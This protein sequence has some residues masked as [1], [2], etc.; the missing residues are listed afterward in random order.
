MRV[1]SSKWKNLSSTESF[2][3]C[4]FHSGES[5][6]FAII[7]LCCSPSARIIQIAILSFLAFLRRKCFQVYL[8]QK[9]H[10][11]CWLLCIQGMRGRICFTSSVIPHFC[12]LD[13]SLPWRN[14][15]VSGF[16][17]YIVQFCAMNLSR[18][19]FWTLSNVRLMWHAW[20]FIVTKTWLD[21][22][23]IAFTWIS[24]F[25]SRNIIL[26]FFVINDIRKCSCYQNYER[27]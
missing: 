13:D 6:I 23:D 15:C 24:S 18:F 16:M 17:L 22:N 3:L 12:R 1:G 14:G 21:W 4:I 19:V 10:S 8:K 26:S 5:Q 20:E 27:P 9:T 11:D 25:F 2:V 7:Q